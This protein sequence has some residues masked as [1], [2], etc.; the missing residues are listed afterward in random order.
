MAA[1]QQSSY[2][3]NPTET[4]PK[5]R[6]EGT[7]RSIDNLISK[8]KTAPPELC[9]QEQKKIRMHIHGGT[10]QSSCI[11]NPT[12]TKPKGRPDGT[13][14]SI[15]NLISKQKIAPPELCKQEQKKIRMHIHGGTQQ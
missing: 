2:I 5:G 7:G 4:K 13:G 3:A 6:P 15:D 1:T 9:K 14:R 12:E 11:A 8:Q 10:R